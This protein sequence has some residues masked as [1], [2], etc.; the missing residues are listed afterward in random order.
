MA[1]PLVPVVSTRYCQLE[2]HRLVGRLVRIEGVGQE[3]IHGRLG[4]LCGPPV[5]LWTEVHKSRSNKASIGTE[6]NRRL[7]SCKMTE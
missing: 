2:D 6:D 5:L 4:R 3:A 7:V 1:V